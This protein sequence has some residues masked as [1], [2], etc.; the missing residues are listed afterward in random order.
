MIALLWFSGISGDTEIGE[1][2]WTYVV[3]VGLIAFLFY[4]LWSARRKP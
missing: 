4:I 2:G 3:L 1:I